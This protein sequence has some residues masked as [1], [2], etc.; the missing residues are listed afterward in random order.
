MDRQLV[1]TVQDALH[2]VSGLH[3]ALLWEQSVS[4]LSLP[5]ATLSACC[6]IRILFSCSILITYGKGNSTHNPHAVAPRPKT[7]NVLRTYEIFICPSLPS[8]EIVDAVDKLSAPRYFGV[9]TARR[10]A[11]LVTCDR[12]ER[13]AA[14]LAEKLDS[15]QWDS[16]LFGLMRV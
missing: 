3:F 6:K 7:I 4:H 11:L 13:F 8:L 15:I 14:W 2:S 5:S 10:L 16:V 12:M 1:H 9:S